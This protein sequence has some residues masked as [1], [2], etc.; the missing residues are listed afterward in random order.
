MTGVGWFGALAACTV[1]V[2]TC[3]LAQTVPSQEWRPAKGPLMTGWAK[4]VSPDKALG[5]YPRPMMVRKDW[6][7]LNGLWDYAVT[8]K[9]VEKPPS[10]YEGKIL[11]PFC[12]ESALSGVMK[13]IKPDQRLWYRRQF[14]V[15]KEWAGRRVLLHFGAVDWE[16]AVALNGRRLGGHRGG[17][18]AFTFDITAALKADGPQDLVVSAWD[19]TDSQWQLRGKQALKPAGCSYTACTGIWQTVWGEPVPQSSIETLR[20]VADLK[21]GVLRLTVTGRLVND[22][23]IIEATA[24][25]G[26]KQVAAERAPAGFG[27]KGTPG[28][29]VRTEWNTPDIWLRREFVLEDVKGRELLLRLHHDE[30]VEVFINGVLAFREEGFIGAYEEVEM[31]AEARG[32]I[33]AGKNVLAVHCHQTSG[34]QY[35][36]VGIVGRRR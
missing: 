11:V 32:A 33:K 28:A 13:P 20:M 19:P 2:A 15:P 36:D 35:V 34:G 17:Y 12:I 30:D 14:T 21:A 6:L 31:T 26:R 5:E 8:G 29:V 1:A 18:D 22:P 7:N 4:D 16:A 3:A 27:T 25:D 10:A 23:M 24:F 9:E